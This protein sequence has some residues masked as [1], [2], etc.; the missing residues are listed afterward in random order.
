MTDFPQDCG[1]CNGTGRISF[2]IGARLIGMMYERPGEAPDDAAGWIIKECP[3]CGGFGQIV[4]EE[5][6]E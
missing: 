1:R 4:G 3:E 5:D 2:K 6:D